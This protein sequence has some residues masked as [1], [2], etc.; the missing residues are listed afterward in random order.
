MADFRFDKLLNGVYSKAK[1]IT[2]CVTVK[3]GETV[4]AAKLKFAIGETEDKISECKKKIGDII[5][6]EYLK[7]KDFE[8]ELG[9]YCRK[10]EN[11]QDDIEVM[12]D[13]MAEVKNSKRC[14]V[15]GALNNEKNTFCAE[16]GE[17]LDKQ[18]EED[19][20]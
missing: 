4:E 3:A 12:K 17:K 6:K 7:T 8:G 20:E 1:H 10:I 5:Y 2:K 16:C 11:L 14:S 13:K 19:D 18:G 15:C 9:E